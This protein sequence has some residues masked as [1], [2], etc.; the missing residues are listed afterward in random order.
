MGEKKGFRIGIFMQFA[1]FFIQSTMWWL[2][3]LSIYRHSFSS[4]I[5]LKK[6]EI[7]T[8]K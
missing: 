3:K 1:G 6:N 2:K 8:I 5:A 7:K 4:L